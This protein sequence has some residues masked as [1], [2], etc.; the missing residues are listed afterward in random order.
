MRTNCRRARRRRESSC[1]CLR[2]RRTL[3]AADRRPRW[4][5]RA[6][7][8]RSG[9]AGIAFAYLPITE[10]S[11]IDDLHTVALVGPD[12]TIDWYCCPRIDS[13]TVFAAILDAD[14]GGLFRISQ[15]CDG[16][17]SKQLYLPNTNIL[18][19]RFLTPDG[20]VEVQD[21]MPPPSTSR[22]PVAYRMILLVLTL[23]GQ[24]RFV[25]DVAPR[26]DY[27]RAGQEVALPRSARWSSLA[28]SSG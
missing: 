21:F 14:H 19:T 15:E 11:L 7:R 26:F 1:S 12:G 27:A 23:R 16:W 5:N 25:V 28:T 10:H 6:R 2:A 20:V 17:S 13:P 4:S 18:T 24:M 8:V 9:S 3:A 22:W